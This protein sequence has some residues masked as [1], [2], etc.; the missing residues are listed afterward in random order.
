[1][2]RFSAYRIY[3]QDGASAGRFV[4][5]A[6]DDLDPGA[7]VIQVHYSSVNY[8][9][10]LAATGTGKVIRRFPCVGGVDAAGVVVSSSNARFKAGDAVIVTGYGM[11]VD[12]DGGFSEFMRVP[13]DWVVPLPQGL[14]LFDAMAIGTAGFAAAL[15][16]HRLEQNELRPESGKVIVTGAT[17]GVA[18]LSIQMLAQLGYH[19][20]ALTGKDSEHA[21]L[22][23]LGAAEIL[24]RKELTMGTRP[25]EKA[26]W[27]GALDAVG[28]ETLAWLTRTMQQNGVIASFGNAGGIELH[29]TVL[30]FILRGVR[31]IGIDSAATAMPLRREIWQ[32]LATDPSTGLRTGLRPKSLAQVA[33]TVPFAELPQVF[34]QL[35]Q[36]KLR[37]RTVVEIKPVS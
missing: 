27:A 33:H 30:P 24:S 15:S 17:G 36:G 19:V 14:T 6:L 21:Y 9:D 12:H 18:S 35:L 28:G 5:L 26:K 20:V 11:G 8:K 37:G 10:A 23:S 13:A 32:R 7:V 34:P 4:E 25:L 22:K 1:M 3:E 29:T 2:K 16:I 31:L